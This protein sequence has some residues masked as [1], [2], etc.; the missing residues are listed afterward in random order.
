MLKAKKKVIGQLNKSY[1]LCQ[2]NE[3]GKPYVL[4]AA[5]KEDPC[6]KFDTE[7]NM[8]EKLWDGPGG[9]MSMEQFAADE[10]ILLATYKFYSPN[11]SA[12]AK[13][14]YYR[15]VDGELKMEVL[16]DLPFV[17]RFGILNRGERRWLIA[18]TLK[19][20]HAFKNDWTCPGRIWVAELPD[21]ITQFNADNQLPMTALVSGLYKNH[22]F[23]KIT[24]GDVTWALVGTE[25]GIWKVVP[26]ENED[27]WK[28][29]C[30]LD[31]PASDM[32]YLDFDKDGQR[33][34]AVLSP[35]HGDTLSVYKKTDGAFEK[36]YENPEK[37]PFL[38]AIYAYEGKKNTYAVI[39]NRQEKKELLALYYEDGS[40]RA[41]IL[42]SGSGPANVMYFDNA[43]E[44]RLIAANRETDEIAMYILSEE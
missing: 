26:P 20:A 40:Y 39:G 9:V 38:H 18:C 19:S 1:S 25:N 8:A 24:E 16:C 36:V 28:A 21:D 11:N 15:R 43:G 31:V 17:H 30:I 7:G 12:D 13:I 37:L 10:F 35:F 3:D 2:V 27:D 33:E 5:E 6:Y 14:V 23:A 41:D 22:G 42:D 44:D 29:E 34:L 4:C 32:L